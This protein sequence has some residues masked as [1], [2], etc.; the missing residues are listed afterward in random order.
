MRP[1]KPPAEPPSDELDDA[2]LFRAA[3]GPVREFEPVE[4]PH[5]RGPAAEPRQREADERAA[6]QQLRD[7]PFA[8]DSP[9]LLLYR[10]PEVAPRVL[11][12]LRRGLYAVQDELDLHGLHAAD[13]ER[14][15]RQFLADVR[16]SGAICVRLI[17]GKGLHSESTGPVL[18]SLVEHL[19]RQ[20]RDVLAY[21]SAPP[22]QG[23]GGAVLVLLARRSPGAA[24][25][26][27]SDDPA[28]AVD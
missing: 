6:L 8:I 23:G 27:E 16:R 2:A 20:R 21:A 15:L 7:A 17:H 5:R 4:M 14:L 1:R 28:P 19:L 26:T 11:K 24:G 12:R 13:A 9:D 3:I 22:A 18:K 10:R 25:V